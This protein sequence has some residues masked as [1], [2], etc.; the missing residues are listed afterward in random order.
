MLVSLERVAHVGVITLRRADK[1]NALNFAMR[2][3]LREAFDAFEADEELRCAV[4]AAEGPVFCAGGDMKEMADAALGEVPAEWMQLTG[5]TGALEKP[6]IAAVAGPALAG[7][8]YLAQSCDLCVVGESATFA[9]TEAKRGRGAPW[10]TP[11][12]SM[13]P[14]RI[15]M[16]LLLTGRPLSARRAYEVGLANAIVPDGQVLDAA[17]QMA[18]EIAANA[19][20]SVRAGKRMVGLAADLGPTMAREP[21]EWLF[22]KAYTSEDARE[23][24]RAFAEKRAPV[25]KGR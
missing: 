17:L 21:S 13:V 4:V 22:R 25:W 1:R 9:I 5:S 16:E 23:G 18:E 20:L 15:M 6:T 8:F 24:P 14:Q 10:A 2:Q 19:P 3:Q 11:L 12:I 7:G